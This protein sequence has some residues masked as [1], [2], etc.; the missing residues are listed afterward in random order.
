MTDNNQAV[1]SLHETT[2]D[3]TA[4]LRALRQR[5]AQ[6][7]QD[8]AMLATE[9]AELLQG[10]IALHHDIRTPLG[11][12]VGYSAL[13]YDES[14]DLLAAEQ[15]QELQLI[16][17][18]GQTLLSTLTDLLDLLKIDANRLELRYEPVGIVEICQD[19]L[20]AVQHD[21]ESSEVSIDFRMHSVP[22]AMQADRAHLVQLLTN[23]LHNAVQFTWRGERVGLEVST[24][25][26]Q[27][28]LS[29]HVWNSSSGIASEKWQAIQEAFEPSTRIT[30]AL[31]RNRGLALA[32]F[33][34]EMHGGCM[35]VE[36]GPRQGLRF[37]V[38]L[39]LQP[40]SQEGASSRP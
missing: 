27:H 15:L 11:V 37:T 19:S 26:R 4:E 31:V 25:D 34:A 22:A 29:F 3:T 20:R 38:T 28:T 8:N 17:R 32:R 39:P 13:I 7:E 18:A 36:S 14:R 1:L 12:I 24:D 2:D 9:K 10:I 30:R 33:L 35:V 16:E 23:L 40:H 5:V 21:A 6:L